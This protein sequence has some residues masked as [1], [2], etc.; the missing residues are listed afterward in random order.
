[1]VTP[2][3]KK[4]MAGYLQ[5]QH[6]LSKRRCAHLV[7]TAPSV[8]R[9]QTRRGGDGAIRERLKA[10]AVERPRWGYRR[11]HILLRREGLLINRKKTHR[12]Y[13]EEKLHLRPK[14]RKRITSSTRGA[15][16]TAKAINDI[17]TMDFVHDNLADGRT[18]RTLNIMDAFSREA[19]EI[20]VDT[21]LNGQRV[22]RVL[23]S[24]V[25]VRGK[26]R[27]IQVDNGS[28]FRGVELDKWAY[29]N[30]VKLHFIEPGKPTQNAKIESFNGRLR[31]ECLNQEWFTSLFHARCVLAAWKD[32]YNFVRPHSALNYQTPTQW[33]H[34]QLRLSTFE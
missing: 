21:S 10:L 22:V 5:E 12:L 7:Q 9:Y 23:E 28:E 26:P 16:E 30:Q 25:A 2:A 20:E 8:L 24:L 17:W 31:D 29:R 18:F 6:G 13:R 11:L 33:A 32:D 4:D 34:N 27:L 15:P 14:K 1:M 3:M 19:L